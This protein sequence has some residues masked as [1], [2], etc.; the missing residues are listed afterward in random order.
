M[1]SFKENISIKGFLETSFLDWPGKIASVIFLPFCNFR[2][3]YCQNSALVLQPETITTIPLDNVLAKLAELKGWI[4]GICITGGEPTLHNTL[5]DFIREFKKRNLLVKLDTNGSNPGMITTLLNENLIDAVAMD[6]KAPLDEI[7]YSRLIGV[8]VDLKKIKESIKLI[9]EGSIETIF[10]V[11][12]VPGLLSEEDIYRLAKNL[13]PAKNLILQQF[14]P[15][16]TLDPNLKEV[17]P[18]TQEKFEQMQQEV[19]KIIGRER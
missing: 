19:D 18:W 4:D 15:E 2:C 5:P 13:S 9:Q 8:S 1:H 7:S 14:Q 17:R 12:V 3:P 16:S 10:R 6:V 11:T